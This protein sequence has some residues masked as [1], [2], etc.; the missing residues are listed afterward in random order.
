MQF[1]SP[2]NSI[3][4]PFSLSPANKRYN[5]PVAQWA[6]PAGDFAVA[7]LDRLIRDREMR[8]RLGTWARRDLA[9]LADAW[10]RAELF[11]QADD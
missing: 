7:A 8:E 1:M 9:M 6:E 2:E 5:G 3:P 11:G 10:S 4:V